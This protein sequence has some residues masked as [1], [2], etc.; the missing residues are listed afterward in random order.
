VRVLLA[1]DDS[2][3]R[4][5]IAR[6]LRTEGYEVYEH[7]D[8]A[9]LLTFLQEQRLKKEVPVD[10]VITD[11]QMPTCSGLEFFL[12]L[13]RL[14]PT[15]PVILITAFGDAQTHAYARHAGAAAVFDKPF[16]IT[17]LLR[18]AAEAI[19]REKGHRFT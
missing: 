11:I 10:L 18:A 15:L 12:V 13:R 8:G 1:E 9:P 14:A 17:E 2:A 5:L 16:E 7:S 19:P 6:S 4:S 3:M